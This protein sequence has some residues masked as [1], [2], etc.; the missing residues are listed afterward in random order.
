MVKN[1]PASVG[2]GRDSDSLPRPGR[3]PEVGNGSPLHYSFLDDSMNRGAWKAIYSPQGH[4]ESDMTEYAH[5]LHA[6]YQGIG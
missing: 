1:P 2:D 3:P 5:M 6:T 4:R